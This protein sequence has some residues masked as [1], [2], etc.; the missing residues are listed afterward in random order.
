MATRQRPTTDPADTASTDSSGEDA[1]PAQ[2][3]VPAEQEDRIVNKVVDRLK[4]YISDV[5]TGGEG[6]GADGPGEGDGASPPEP[7][8]STPREVEAA[9]ED[10]VRAAV[11]K[12]NAEKEHAAEHAKLR[13][14]ERPPQQFSRLTKALWGDH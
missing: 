11:E 5:V 14:P 10:A 3:P 1:P 9:S 2:P 13:E 4:N 6:K 7:E 8:P 12:I